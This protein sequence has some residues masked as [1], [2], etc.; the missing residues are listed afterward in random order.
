MYL[1]TLKNLDNRTIVVNSHVKHYLIRKYN[2]LIDIDY[3]ADNTVTVHDIHDDIHAVSL[4]ANFKG[5]YQHGYNSN[6]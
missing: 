6:P 2:A 4:K 5:K 1:A 3:H